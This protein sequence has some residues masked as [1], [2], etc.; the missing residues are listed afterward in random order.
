MWWLLVPA[1]VLAVLVAGIYI[2]NGFFSL[3]GRSIAEAKEALRTKMKDPDSM[4]I[5]SMFTTKEISKDS[6]QVS[7]G[8]CGTFYG[9]NSYG[10]YDGGLR[11]ISHV[12]YKDGNRLAGITEIEDKTLSDI[13][14]RHN[15]QTPIESS[16]NIF[17]VDEIHHPLPVPEK[18]K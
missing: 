14:N 10:A 2:W 4:R 17:C 5:E 6:R 16:W 9:K 1:A 18:S 13:Y 11:F 12:L 3:E 8:V 15:E 7:I